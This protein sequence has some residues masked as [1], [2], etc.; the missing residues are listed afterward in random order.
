MFDDAEIQ[1][2]LST[3]AKNPTLYEV[4]CRLG[5]FVTD[6]KQTQFVPGIA[7]PD[8]YRMIN[9][10]QQ[11]FNSETSTT[12]Q[13]INGQMRHENDKMIK[14]EPMGRIDL[15]DYDVRIALSKETAQQAARN[16]IFDETSIMR[17]FCYT[18]TKKRTSFFVC[19]ELRLDFTE[20]YSR[21]GDTLDGPEVTYEVELEVVREISPGALKDSIIRLIQY[22]RETHYVI[23]KSV[24][25]SMEKSFCQLVGVK[26]L[27]FF[28]GAQPRT[29][30]Q[31]DT[32]TLQAQPYAI[33][34]KLDG[35]RSYL[36]ITH[37]GMVT[38]IT[39]SVM[40]QIA[41]MDSSDF[42]ETV[43]DGELTNAFHAF[44]VICWKGRD[45]RGNEM[46]GSLRTRLA[47][48]DLIVRRTAQRDVFRAKEYYFTGSMTELQTTLK[49]LLSKPSF[50]LADVDGIIF[51]PSEEMYPRTKIWRGLMKWK[52]RV[53]I[54]FRVHGDLLFVNSAHREIEFRPEDMHQVG[55]LRQTFTSMKCDDGEIYECYWE[56]NLKMFIPVRHR[57]DKTKPNFINIA[58]DNFYAMR[59][60][61]T[62]SVLI[63]EDYVPQGYLNAA[64]KEKYLVS[65]PDAVGIIQAKRD[66][67]IEDDE[68]SGVCAAEPCLDICPDVAQA[69][70]LDE[71]V[72]MDEYEDDACE[73]YADDAEAAEMQSDEKAEDD[74]D[75]SS[76]SSESEQ[77]QHAAKAP[78]KTQQ[79][80]K[81]EPPVLLFGKPVKKWRLAELK[82]A[83]AERNLK[84]KGKKAVLIEHLRLWETKN[85]TPSV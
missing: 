15:V 67:A 66:E 62:L 11:T 74:Q 26:N 57:G 21:Q 47:L 34:H 53:T 78:R 20:V 10:H 7:K 71:D 28:A 36:Y 58:L 17:I 45:L 43:L 69:S 25:A 52:P 79:R 31:D 29:M 48:I 40:K 27:S 6:G 14:K 44:D 18:R 3:Y 50:V 84:I 75:D 2:F 5:Q 37:R 12:S 61:V 73:E 46:F 35:V 76:E 30:Q 59:N 63:G 83:C 38:L 82:V 19:P 81:R 9:F 23:S 4:E 1:R 60:P 64:R 13:R 68:N 32:S 22:W 16:N 70:A 49:S 56:P 55:T 85:G 54:D 51:V 24:V 8:F 42:D 65:I 39:G 80:G 33:T 72:V 41:W 77:E